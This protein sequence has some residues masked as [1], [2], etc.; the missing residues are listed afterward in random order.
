MRVASQEI[1]SIVH[2]CVAIL[3]SAVIELAALAADA[4]ATRLEHR[5][6][7]ECGL[8]RSDLLAGARAARRIA[9]SIRTLKKGET[10]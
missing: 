7:Y 9:I 2:K 8:G 10:S 6:D 3:E 5:A 1:E 4:E